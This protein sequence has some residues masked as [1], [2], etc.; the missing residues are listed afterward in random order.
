MN[1]EDDQHN[2][3]GMVKFLRNVGVNVEV[4]RDRHGVYHLAATDDNGHTYRLSGDELYPLTIELCQQLG[5][6]DMD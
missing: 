6:E 4:T 1:H 2:G 5:F 3:N